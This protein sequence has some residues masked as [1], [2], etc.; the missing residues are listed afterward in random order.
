MAPSPKTAPTVEAELKT[1]RIF[2]DKSSEEM[3]DDVIAAVGRPDK[4]GRNASLARSFESTTGRGWVIPG[5]GF[6]C[7]AIPDPGG[8]WATGCQ[9]SS[10]VAKHGLAVGLRRADSHGRPVGRLTIAAA[11]P[12]GA[13]PP[14]GMHADKFGVVTGEAD[15]LPRTPGN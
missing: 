13:G 11:L 6:A 2:T 14:A 8:G 5:N 3:P 9:E 10:H 15:S 4:F 1:L 7:I 12:N